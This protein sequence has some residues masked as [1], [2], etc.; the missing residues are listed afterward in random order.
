MGESELPHMYKA[1][2]LHAI[3]VKN[4]FL[5]NVY[6]CNLVLQSYVNS[7]ALSEA[8]KL[9]HHLPQTNI[10]SFNTILSGFFKSRLVSEALEFFNSSPNRDCQSWNIVISGCV[11]NQRLELALTHFVEMR[12]SSIRPDRYTYSIVIPCCEL[13]F[14]QQVHAEVIKV[15]SDSDAFLGTNLLGMYAGVGDMEAAKKVFDGMPVRDLVAWNALIACYS[16]CGT[17]DA[18][19]GLF[20]ELA[21][22]GILADEYTYATVLNE[23]ASRLQVFETMQVHSLLIQRGFCSDCFIS[24]SLLNLYS[25]SG[26]IASAFLLFQEMPH[27]DVVSW[28]TIIS[29]FSQCGYVKEAFLMFHKMRLD[30]VEPNSF[31]FGGLLGA[32]A[33]A[34]AFHSGKQIHGIVLRIGLETDV[35]VA[36]AIVDMYSKSGAMDDSVRI[37]QS[38]FERDIV[39]WNAIICGFAQNGEAMKA[40]KL[41]DELVLYEPS[42][43]A[44]NDVTFVGVLSA[45]GH[46]GL[47]EEGCNYLNEMVHKHLIKP[48]MEHYTCMVDLLARAGLLEEAEVLMR[49]FPYEP[50]DVMWSTL[51]GACKLHGNLQMA[52]H[53]GEHLYGDELWNSSN[54]VLLS[55]SYT[56]VG[57]W[58]EAIEIRNMMDARGVR[59]IIGCSWV[60]IESCMHLFIAGDKLHPCIKAICEML[61]RLYFQMKERYEYELNFRWISL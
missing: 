4:G 49:S 19:I 12:H 13:G 22:E 5:Y 36:S 39:L 34:S 23:F 43:V 16:K 52:R 15:G 55:T 26:F 20:Q 59:K 7:G 50:D 41:Y 17:G 35:V 21:K 56:D 29:G 58:S 18:S 53:I 2:T 25:K 40:L 37:F 11:R 28:T 8:Y 6:Q 1:Q 24:N 57:R 33:D 3:L 44:P 42:I 60:E 47:V 30:N 46:A 61:Q 9:L 14:G 10:V 51:L 48:K 32:C 45:C 38:M 54:Y 31:T 27:Q